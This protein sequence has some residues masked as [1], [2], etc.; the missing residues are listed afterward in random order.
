MLACVACWVFFVFLF[1]PLLLQ[2]ERALGRRVLRV[3][4]RVGAIMTLCLAWRWSDGNGDDSEAD[5]EAVN[6]DGE[7]EMW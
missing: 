2:L 1:I 3:V 4:A 5:W 6:S 7:M